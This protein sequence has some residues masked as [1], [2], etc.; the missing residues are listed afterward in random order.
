MDLTLLPGALPSGDTAEIGRIGTAAQPLLKLQVD[1]L[2]LLPCQGKMEYV[3]ELEVSGKV[4]D[5]VETLLQVSQPFPLAPTQGRA[6]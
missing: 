3:F 4:E 5:V 2:L 6:D 1:V